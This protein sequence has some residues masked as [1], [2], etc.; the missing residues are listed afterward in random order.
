MIFNRQRTP[1][2]RITP[3][4]GIYVDAIA[5]LPFIFNEGVGIEYSDTINDIDISRYTL[6]SLLASVDMID[7]LKNERLKTYNKDNQFYSA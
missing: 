1:Q 3:N 4:T 5:T 2:I 7:T 6:D